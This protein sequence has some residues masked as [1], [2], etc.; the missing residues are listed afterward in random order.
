MIDLDELIKYWKNL[1]AQ[2]D[3]TLDI[4]IGRWEYIN[5]TIVY[6]EKLEDYRN[7]VLGIHKKLQGSD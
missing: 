2:G 4:N 6:L 7:L 3:L 5:A 1:N